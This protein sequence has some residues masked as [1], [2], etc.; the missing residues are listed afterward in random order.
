MEA[1]GNGAVA[2]ASGGHRWEDDTLRAYYRA[3]HSLGAKWAEVSILG[4]L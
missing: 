4:R 1:K 2:K 3:Y